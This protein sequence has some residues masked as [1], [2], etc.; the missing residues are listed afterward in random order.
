LQGSQ[1]YYDA[2]ELKGII[3]GVRDG[4][5]TLDTVTSTGGLRQRV[6]ELTEADE[7]EKRVS[8]RAST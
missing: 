6:A 5:W 3:N 7:I 4:R 8:G 1:K 2:A